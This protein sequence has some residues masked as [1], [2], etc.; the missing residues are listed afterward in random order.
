MHFLL[1]ILEEKVG[2]IN[3]PIARK[4]GSI[5][6]RCISESGQ[7]A[8]THYNVIKEFKV[9]SLV[10]FTLETGRTHQIRVHS[11]YIGHPILR[12]YTIWKKH[13]S[14]TKAST[15]RIQT[16]LSPSHNPKRTRNY[17]SDS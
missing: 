9:L 1:G 12:R 16:D 15:S 13:L 8:I 4:E 3:E 11:Q 7:T 10:H 14:Y 17:R 2:T 6:E 5:I